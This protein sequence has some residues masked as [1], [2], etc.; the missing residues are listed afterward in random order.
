MTRDLVAMNCETCGSLVRVSSTAEG[1]CSYEPLVTPERLA[2]VR[3]FARNG[4]D[5]G[6]SNNK[7]LRAFFREV[8]EILDALLAVPS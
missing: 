8:M 3:E 5:F 6:A 1:T 7:A 2:V 4:A